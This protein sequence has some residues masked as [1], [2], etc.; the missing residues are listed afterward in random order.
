MAR[1][2]YRATVLASVLTG[3]VLCAGGAMAADDYYAGKTV[4]VLVSSSP[5]G[6]TDATARLVS[7]FLPKFI[8]GNPKTIVQNMPGGGG[9]VVNNYYTRR[10]KPDGLT[11]LQDSS[12]AL[13]TYVRGGKR[14]K[15]NPRE[16]SYIGSIMRGGS[17]LMV[18][19]DARKRLTD[20]KAKPVVVGDSDGIRTWVAMTVW[21]SK[22]LGWNNRWIFGYA[23]TGEMVLALRQGEIEMWGT[24]NAKL[25]RD[26]QR[27]GVV[28]PLVL[29][30]D[31]RRKDFPDVPTFQELLVD[32]RPSGVA[33]QAYK[34]WAGPSDVD[35][36]LHAPKGTPASVMKTLHG[37][38]AKMVK[39]AKFQ[40]EATKFF[41]EAWRTRDGAATAKLVLEVTNA[42]QEVKDFLFNI[43]KEHGLPTGKKK[44]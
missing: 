44:K 19:K 24:G 1:R 4:T 29:L 43:R 22:Y 27:D 17:V 20:P 25:I 30:T 38:W 6:G 42:S 2:G 31:K 14:V 37:A 33:W 12:S 9:T 40:T 32:K 21:G 10:A 35:K 34:V 16:Y 18:R 26:L 7:R 15:F 13:S 39:D 23:G 28:D 5:G 41:G 8:P 36:F 11:L 3:V